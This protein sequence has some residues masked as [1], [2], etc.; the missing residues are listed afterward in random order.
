[1]EAGP[2]PGVLPAPGAS[3]EVK[4]LAPP[5]G[6]GG[7]QTDVSTECKTSKRSVHTQGA[8]NSVGRLIVAPVRFLGFLYFTS[9][10]MLKKFT[11]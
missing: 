7:R 10:L 5:R 2:Q 6:G 11:I 4:E 3:F 1:M 9:Y 8:V